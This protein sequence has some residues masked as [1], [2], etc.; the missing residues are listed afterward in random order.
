MFWQR[1]R[2]AF[3]SWFELSYILD[4]IVCFALLLLTG[5]FLSD[6]PGL[7][8]PFDRYI[9]PEDSTIVYPWRNQIFPTWLLIV[10]IVVIPLTVFFCMQLVAKS[11][12]DL[13]HAI[14]GILQGQAIT[15]F[16]TSL[17]K[18]LAGRPR[19]DYLARLK[20]PGVSHVDLREGRFSF[21]S[22]HASISFCAMTFL[23][24]YL[25]GKLHLF[26]P[27]THQ[28]FWKVL[29]ALSPMVISL[30]IAV[31]RTMDYHHHFADIT[32]GSVIGIFGACVGY[33][34]NY[35]SLF[36]SQCHLPRNRKQTSKQQQQ[37][38]LEESNV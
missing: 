3:I 31:S 8:P 24:F 6:L 11:V 4:W 36:S 35:Y 19:P 26:G 16:V 30:L 15:F 12:H 38:R 17:L 25:S 37:I 7:I 5:I 29:L 27:H 14:L 10:I 21:P 1:T 22:G 18:V 23:F 34:T 32:A 13:H 20:T 2:K 28:A 33:A 9:P